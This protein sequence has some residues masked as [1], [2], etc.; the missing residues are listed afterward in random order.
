M[1]SLLI[2]SL[3]PQ[4][5]PYYKRK[6]QLTEVP[7]SYSVYTL[8]YI[9]IRNFPASLSSPIPLHGCLHLR[10]RRR[11]EIFISRF[12]RQTDDNHHNPTGKHPR[13]S[14]R[15]GK[16]ML[17][18]P[19]EGP[20]INNK[21]NQHPPKCPGLRRP[22]PAHPKKQRKGNAGSHQSPGLGRQIHNRPRRVQG[23]PCTDN[24]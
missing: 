2:F 17:P 12:R 1:Q 6:Q 11:Q 20:D 7:F 19:H 13:H 18:N 22:A 5:C 9:L 4:L 14:R 21:P 3:L 24:G 23:N 10:I 8:P 15:K 16:G